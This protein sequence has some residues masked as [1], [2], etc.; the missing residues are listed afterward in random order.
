MRMA[1]PITLALRFLGIG[2]GS[3]E[4][5]ARKSLYGAIAGIGISLVP[6]IVVLVLADGMIEGSSRRII[7]LSSAH[8][9]VSDYYGASGVSEDPDA[10]TELAARL[11]KENPDG[12]IVGAIAERQGLGIVIGKGARMGGT[13]RAVEPRF[14][15]ENPDVTGLLKVVAGRALLD[16]ADS[17]ILGKK[18][19]SDLGLS[20]G[21][22]FRILTMRGVR[23]Q[24]NSALHNIPCLG[25]RFL[26]IPG[27]RRTLGFYSLQHGRAHPFRAGLLVLRERPYFRSLREH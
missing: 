4:S 12:E 15:T 10:L 8:L 11:P 16:S 5:N 6:L 14:F 24:I 1:V 18:I 22:T 19:A 3:Q 13:V 2:S 9:R 23:G 20:V 25:D 17:A 27:T 7:E 21:D 26:R